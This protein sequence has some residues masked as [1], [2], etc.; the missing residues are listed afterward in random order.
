VI[1]EVLMRLF[2]VVAITAFALL[3]LRECAARS[4]FK[5]DGTINGRKFKIDHDGGRAR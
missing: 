2:C 1:R 4:V 5:L 3:A